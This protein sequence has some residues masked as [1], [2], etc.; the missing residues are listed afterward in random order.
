VDHSSLPSRGEG[1]HEVHLERS[2]D[3]QGFGF[4]LQYNKSYYLVHRVEAG[5]PAEAAGL[6]TNDVIHTINNQKTENMEHAD[7]VQIVS[8]SS[9]VDFLVQGVNEYLRAHPQ[10]P[11]NQQVATSVAAAVSGENDKHKNGLSKALSKL[12]NR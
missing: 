12:T 3:F 6:R 9:G 8:A 11:R 2:P 10:P 5:S 7:F 1:L 4:H